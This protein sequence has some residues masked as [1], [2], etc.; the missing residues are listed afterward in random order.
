MTKAVVTR[1]G[2]FIFGAVVATWVRGTTVH[3]AEEPAL[4][5]QLTERMT[6]ALEAQARATSELVRATEKLRR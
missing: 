2:W 4:D 3:A 6:R 5:R 1:V